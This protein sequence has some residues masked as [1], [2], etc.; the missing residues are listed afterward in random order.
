MKSIRLWLNPNYEF[1]PMK[2][3]VSLPF[4]AKMEPLATLVPKSI[5]ISP[6]GAWFWF[7][8][9]FLLGEPW[10]DGEAALVM[11]LNFISPQSCFTHF[12]E[13]L[14]AFPLHL[15]L[16]YK[17]CIQIWQVTHRGCSGSS[18]SHSFSSFDETNECAGAHWQ[19]GKWVPPIAIRH[20]TG[21]RQKH[22][23]N[24]GAV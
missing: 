4:S 2:W 1:W 8:I 13:L 17:E 20:H 19:H 21:R 23:F 18:V 11:V 12:Q 10:F 22:D 16:T 7:Y 3:R 9:V 14:V 5:F 6:G 24:C 15:K